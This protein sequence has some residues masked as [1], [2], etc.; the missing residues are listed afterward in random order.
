MTSLV[1]DGHSRRVRRSSRDHVAI[2]IHQIDD[3]R[4][5][6]AHSS[7]AR[8]RRR[9]SERHSAEVGK[10]DEAAVLLVVLHDP[11]S[12]GLAESRCRREVFGDLLSGGSVLNDG[13][14]GSRGGRG[15]GDGD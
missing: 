13:G 4:T 2:V 14:T 8:R 1:S 11:L 9:T 15:D 3:R 5:V 10:R 12:V 7:T 6:W